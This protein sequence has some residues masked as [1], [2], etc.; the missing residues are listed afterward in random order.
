[1]LPKTNFPNNDVVQIVAKSRQ[2][3]CEM[4]QLQSPIQ[5]GD[6]KT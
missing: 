4:K 5:T 2:R 6:P 1:M 3:N